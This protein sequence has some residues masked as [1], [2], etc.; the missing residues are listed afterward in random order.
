MSLFTVFAIVITLTAIFSYLNEIY[1]KLPGTIGIMLASLISSIIFLVLGSIGFGHTRWAT[2]LI[3]AADFN[4]LFM[5]GM[6]SFLLFAAASRVDVGKLKEFAWTIAYL[7]TVGIVISSLF[8][9][10]SMYWIVSQFG[11]DLPILYA[12]LFGA[13]ISPIDAVVVIKILKRVDAGN[14]METIITGEALFNDAAAVVLFV[15]LL[16]LASGTTSMTT[17]AIGEFFLREALGGLAL[18]LVLGYVVHFMIVQI[19][20]KGSDNHIVIILLTLGLV[21]GGYTLA[22]L[23][24]VSGPLTS[25]VSGLF[26][27]KSR[28]DA[29]GTKHEHSHYVRDFWEVVDEV[30][31]AVLFV[32]IGLEVLILDFKQTY[33]LGCS[34]VIPIIIIAR[35]VSVEFPLVLLRF[36]RPIPKIKGLIMTWSGIRGGVSIALALSLPDDSPRDILLVLTYIVV[37]F[38]ILVQGLTL[39]PA[40]KWY[41][42][43]VGLE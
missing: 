22:G 37:V 23:L 40:V 15:L 1:I 32:L 20:Y 18:G 27:A 29:I 31:N 7:A 5:N 43:R 10:F 28:H 35:Y 2:D 9:G 4:H 3:V 11:V 26:L 14:T 6:L 39:G 8:I 16:G 38:S 21:S 12:I 13:I 19:I 33:F 41:K 34:L 42:K 17:M 30:L 25:V 36:F 24:D